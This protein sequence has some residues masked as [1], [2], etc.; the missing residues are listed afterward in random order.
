MNFFKRLFNTNRYVFIHREEEGLPM[1]NTGMPPCI[2]RITSSN[3][4][5]HWCSYNGI[6]GNNKKELLS[7]VLDIIKSNGEL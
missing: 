7:L 4:L 5:E 2:E 1:S 3:D 6:Q